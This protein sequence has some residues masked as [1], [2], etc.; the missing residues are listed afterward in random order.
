MNRTR[1]KICGITRSQDAL[2]A[3]NLGVDALGLVFVASSPRCV[4]IEQ[5]KT[6]VSQLPPFVQTVALFMNNSA[7][8]IR[9]ILQAVPLNLLQFHGDETPEFCEQF[10]MP[11][12]K[13]VAMGGGLE[14]LQYAKRYESAT[15][16]LLDSHAKGQS[17]GSGDAFDWQTI[18]SSFN[19][20]LIL[21]GGLTIEN[22]ATAVKQV[23]PYAVDVS[24]GVEAAKGVKDHEKMAAFVRGVRQGDE[25]TTNS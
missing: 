22:V 6:I 21:A 12:I 13:A 19:K 3:I 17:G 4:N 8:E 15:G 11:Y 9:Q 23:K 5:S 2:D 7:D 16:F 25:S 1:I 18:P 10:A 24:S 14:P 20:S